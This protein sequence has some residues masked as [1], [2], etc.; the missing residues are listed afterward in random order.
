MTGVKEKSL[1]TVSMYL[2]ALRAV[3]NKAI[4]ENEIEQ[5]FYPFGKRKYQVPA[6]KNTKKALSKEQLRILFNAKIESPEQEKAKL[7]TSPGSLI[8]T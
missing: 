6:T 1:T 4:E 7:I 2:R 5:E 3:Y 8:S